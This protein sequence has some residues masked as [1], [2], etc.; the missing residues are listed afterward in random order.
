MLEI[1]EGSE[2]HPQIMRKNLC[3]RACY[4]TQK[5]Y[6]LCFEGGREVPYKHRRAAGCSNLKETGRF[7]TIIRRPLDVKT[8]T[9]SIVKD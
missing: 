4:E 5:R 8:R 1:Y 9:V 2:H 6:A 7:M 3:C